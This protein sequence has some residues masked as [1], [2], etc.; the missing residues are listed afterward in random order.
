MVNEPKLPLSSFSMSG[1]SI[2]SKLVT[3]SQMDEI[4]KKLGVQWKTLAPHLDVKEDEI[5]DIEA[6]GDDVELQAKM[7]L[8]SW[9]DREDAQATMES[10][11]TALIAAGFSSIAQAF[12]ET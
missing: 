8:V 6:D 12:S 4:A 9:Q 5:R 11:V 10:L 7:M 1:P 3:N 2:Q